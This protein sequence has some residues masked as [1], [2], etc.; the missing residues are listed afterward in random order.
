MQ[1]VT[2]K[3]WSSHNCATHVTVQVT[4]MLWV[5]PKRPMGSI[6]MTP[7][8]RCH[9]I[10]EYWRS[11]ITV[12][13][14]FPTRL[15]FSMNRL[16]FILSLPLPQLFISPINGNLFIFLYFLH[17]TR[18]LLRFSLCFFWLNFFWVLLISSLFFKEVTPFFRFFSSSFSLILIGKP[19]LEYSWLSK[20]IKLKIR[21]WVHGHG[22]IFREVNFQI[23]YLYL[24]LWLFKKHFVSLLKP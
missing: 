13:S 14:E 9:C 23:I 16:F 24:W 20:I 4:N 5:S 19:S 17:I 12:L 18:L 22:L 7:F 3:Y 15:L 1:T 11:T 2:Q 10:L 8:L 6:K 21:W